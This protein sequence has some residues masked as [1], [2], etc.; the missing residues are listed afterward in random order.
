MPNGEQS[1][2]VH[3]GTVQLTPT[4]VLTNVLHVSDFQFNLLSVSK[5]CSQLAGQ[6]TF[7]SS[8]CVL[9]GP[10]SQVVVLGRASRGLYHTGARKITDHKVQNGSRQSYS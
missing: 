6:V 3:I 7:T 1:K 4:L 10:M 8:K 5:L 2:I 9:Q